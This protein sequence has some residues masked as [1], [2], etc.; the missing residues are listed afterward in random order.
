MTSHEKKKYDLFIFW[1]Y[2]SLVLIFFMVIVGGLTRLTNS[3]L[4][5]TEWELFKGT[6]PPFN[7]NS[8]AYYF[9]LY[10]KIPQ[11]DIV[12]PHMTINEFKVIF[13]WEY[14]HRLLGRLI[15]IFFLI[16]LIYFTI[17][18]VFKKND[19]LIF[20]FIFFLICLQGLIG[21]YMVQSG[22]VDNVTVSHY[23]LSLHLLMAF[24]IIGLIFWSLLN[25]LYLKT[26]TNQI[27]KNKIFFNI[28]IFLIFLQ[29]FF[30]ALVSG[31]DAGK[32]YQTWPLMNESYY[33][34]DIKIINLFELDNRSSVQFLH[35]NLAYFLFIYTLF[36]GAQIYYKHKYLINCYIIVFVLIF[37]QMSLGIITLLSGINNYIALLHQLTGVAL[38]LGSIFLRFK[39]TL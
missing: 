38:F 9:D 3:G 16:P 14:F 11:Y 12:N 33:P 8:W 37:A 21:W 18:K 19:L 39:L 1:L 5:I 32:I 25:S 35:R 36:L 13:Y 7:E 23:R 31:L 6:L 28:L 22:L 29:I 17:K 20:Y 34:N 30:G 26:E 4:S 24:I 27:N 15:G 2:S 10:K